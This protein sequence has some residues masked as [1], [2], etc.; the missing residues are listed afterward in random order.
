LVLSK[1]EVVVHRILD[2]ENYPTDELIYIESIEVCAIKDPMP[3]DG[4][5]VFTGK[6]LFTMGKKTIFDDKKGHTLLKKINH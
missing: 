2:T 5:C 4:P 1:L 6:G 3:A